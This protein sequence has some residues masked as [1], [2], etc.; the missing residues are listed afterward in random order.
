MMLVIYCYI[1]SSKIVLLQKQK[2]S[3]AFLK[4]LWIMYLSLPQELRV[5][6][7]ED[8]LEKGLR[9]MYKMGS[10]VELRFQSPNCSYPIYQVC[11]VLV[12]SNNHTSFCQVVLS[13]QRGQM[14]SCLDATA[15]F[16]KMSLEGLIHPP[17]Q[18]RGHCQISC[19]CLLNLLHLDC[20]I[21]C[22]LSHFHLQPFLLLR[23]LYPPLLTIKILS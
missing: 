23:V 4:E 17:A 9:R 21:Y 5:T 22:P 13:P 16:L 3:D 11:Q 1:G 10:E 12:S 14:Q 2:K 6:Q 20:T 8:S 18:I 7:K 19:H 15:S